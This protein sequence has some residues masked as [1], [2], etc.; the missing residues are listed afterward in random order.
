MKHCPKCA[1]MKEL[2]DFTRDAKRKDGL[3]SWCRQCTKIGNAGWRSKNLAT[4]ASY[5]AKWKAADPE[6]ALALER[7]RYH[8]DP[9]KSIAKT[10]RWQEE[11]PGEASVLTVRK[12]TG[13]DQV[14][15]VWADIAAI[16][17]VYLLA[18][19]VSEMTGLRTH[20][21]HIVPLRS[22]YVCGLHVHTNLQVIPSGENLAKGNKYWPD[23]W[24]IE[25]E[26]NE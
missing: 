2:S 16:G 12:R 15:P 13:V 7:D 11:N 22:R 4:W 25:G 10:R 23:M 8:A 1:E 18:R 17:A 9:K 21:D 20:V 19:A 5:T 14:A 24:P 26:G 3:R 6:H